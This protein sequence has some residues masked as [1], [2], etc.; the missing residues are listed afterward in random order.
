MS[1]C[2]RESSELQYMMDVF[3]HMCAP[4]REHAMPGSCKHGC[5]CDYGHDSSS[6]SWQEVIARLVVAV[7][8][9]AVA[10]VAAIAAAPEL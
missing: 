3:G 4:V 10:A 2:C 7:S 9:A 5:S 1:T 8:V 6:S